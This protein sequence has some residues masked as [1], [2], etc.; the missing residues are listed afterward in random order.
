MPTGE[1]K[2]QLDALGSFIRAQRL[3][4]NLTLRDLAA[5]TRV[6]NAYLS[7][8]ERGLHEPSLSVLKA[9]ADG[10]SLPLEALLAQ[11][12]VLDGLSAPPVR[13]TER[14][15]LEDDELTE[16]QRIALLSVYRGFVGG[17]RLTE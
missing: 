8:L 15:I 4:T 17:S 9:I 5:R 2:A 13:D 10:L 3:I 16:S 7:Q 12:G 14:A 6:S 1:S 11:A